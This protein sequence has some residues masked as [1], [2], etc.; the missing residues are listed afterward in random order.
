MSS[1]GKDNAPEWL[2][3]D[4]GENIAHLSS[5]LNFIFRYELPFNIVNDSCLHGS[6]VLYDYTQY[7]QITPIG[8]SVIGRDGGG[9]CRHPLTRIIFWTVLLKKQPK[10]LSLFDTYYKDQL[11]KDLKRHK[12]ISTDGTDNCNTL[13]QMV[14][15]FNTDIC[16]YCTK[17]G[18]FIHNCNDCLNYNF[19]LMLLAVMKNGWHGTSEFGYTTLSY[20]KMEEKIKYTSG[21]NLSFRGVIGYFYYIRHLFHEFLLMMTDKFIEIDKSEIID[22]DDSDTLDSDDNK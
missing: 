3:I 19:H 8:S 2:S 16:I 13:E 18:K 1:I 14:K 7:I 22:S 20:R 10:Y 21:Y 4:E 9:I 17:S 15:A 5:L 11:N 6:Y 12:F